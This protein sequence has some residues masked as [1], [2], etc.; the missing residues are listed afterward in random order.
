MSQ[1]Q[2][3]KREVTIDQF[4]FNCH[5]HAAWIEIQFRVRI[6]IRIENEIG[7]HSAGAAASC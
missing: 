6:R 5:L 4:A 1:Q 3:R 2:V 7:S